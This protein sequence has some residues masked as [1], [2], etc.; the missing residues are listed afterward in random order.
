MKIITTENL[1]KKSICFIL[2]VILVSGVALSGCKPNGGISG[3]NSQKSNESGMENSISGDSLSDENSGSQGDLSSG[4]GSNGNSAS[5][6]GGTSAGNNGTNATPTPNTAKLINNVYTSGYPIVK[7]K[8]KIKIMTVK[9]VAHGDFDKMRFTTELEKKMNVDIEWQLVPEFQQNER[10]ALVLQSGNLPDIMMLFSGIVTDADLV[11]YSKE[12]VFLEIGSK[13]PAW[14]P[15]L[16]KA[17]DQYP[18]AKAAVTAPDG[19][20]YSLPL[21]RK[22]DYVHYWNINKT[23]LDNLDM[24]VPKTTAQL[25]EVMKAFKEDDPNGNGKNDEIPFATF[26]WHPSLWA[27]WG[28]PQSFENNFAVDKNGKVRYAWTTDNFKE[29][30]KFWAKAYREGLL[31]KDSIDAPD[32]YET[33][34]QLLKTKRVGIFTWSWP[35][36]HL[37]LDI[38]KD[39]ELMAYPDSEYKNSLFGTPTTT[40]KPGVSSHTQITKAAKGKLEAVLRFLD[41]FYTPEGY[42]YKTYA[43]AGYKYYDIVN[44][45]FKTRN[46]EGLNNLQ[47]A[48][49]W[50]F[51]G[52]DIVPK[53][54]VYQKKAS[55]QTAYDKFTTD[56]AEKAETIYSAQKPRIIFPDVILSDSEYQSVKNTEYWFKGGLRNAIPFFTGEKNI[57]TQWAEYY[58]GIVNDLGLAKYESAYQTAYDRTK[59]IIG[60]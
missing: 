42:Y 40:I 23:W 11:K 16:K 60:K 47:D 8:I 2:S 38:A 5:V 53:S 14:A 7:D 21:I 20:I 36:E 3:T 33:Y 46:L 56:Y 29:G 50:V 37:G 44:G 48:P 9:N 41:F 19:K 22:D 55:E 17:M 39:Y 58:N 49:S 54:L 18:Y 12:G 51:T 15:N 6:S 13:I 25:Y 26:T 10:K 35:A 32:A 4:N 28:L 31:Y 57:D 52:L 45:L 24:E 59:K 1:K 27:P 30:I 34:K 43:D